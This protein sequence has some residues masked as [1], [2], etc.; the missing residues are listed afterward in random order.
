MS[1][2]TALGHV[3][4]GLQNVTNLLVK[5]HGLL[6]AEEP[7]SNIAF[8]IVSTNIWQTKKDMFLCQMFTKWLF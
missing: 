4:Y 1:F 8:I 7:A 5:D 2:Y 3:V 6:I